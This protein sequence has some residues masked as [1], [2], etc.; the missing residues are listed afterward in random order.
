MAVTATRLGSSPMTLDW[1]QMRITHKYDPESFAEVWSQL[2]DRFASREVGFYDAPVDS[3]LSDIQACQELAAQV[4]QNPQISDCL[5]LG[6]GGSALGPISLLSALREKCSTRIRFHFLEN[7]DPLEWKSTL[8]SLRPDSTL[9]CSVTKSG[10]TFETMAQTLLALQWLGRERWKTHFV[11]ITDPKKGDLRQFASDEG[12]KT[13]SIHPSIGG[14]FSVFSSVGLFPAALAGLSLDSF[15]AGAAQIREYMDKCPGE[16]NP[17]F[18]LADEFIRQYPKRSTHVCMPYSTRLKSLGAW[19]V[20]LWGE[21]LGKDGKGFNPL[22]ALGATDQHSILQLLRDGPDDKVTFFITVDHV[23]DP[24]SIPKVSAGAG[25]WKTYPAFKILE[26]HSLHELMGIEQRSIALVLSRQTRPSLTIRLDRLDE[27]SMGA[28]FFFFS[29]LTAFT[30]EK[31][32][33]NPF[34][35]PGVEE[36]KVYIREALS[37]Q[38]D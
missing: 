12:L 4:L 27:K 35:Q 5:F 32:G 26:G 31:W 29:V 21:S 25:Q 10:T 28:V 6:I 18:I 15:L 34:D 3:E 11:A 23:E 33:V 13:L 9:V 24:I 14:R 17:I 1:T 7:P 30:G 20:Q 2:K 36:G 16:K 8:A 37:Q 22:A 38:R 19:F